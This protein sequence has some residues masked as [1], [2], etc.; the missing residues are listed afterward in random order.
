MTEL[1]IE[2][3]KDYIV[4]TIYFEV[5]EVELEYSHHYNLGSKTCDIISDLEDN[6]NT[7]IEL[8]KD[9]EVV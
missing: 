6:M 1:N 7:L 8:N 4:G 3:Q 9:A 5:H 2:T